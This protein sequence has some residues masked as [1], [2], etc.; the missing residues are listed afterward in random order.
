M[1]TPS[2]GDY[3][4]EGNP[5]ATLQNAD[6]LATWSDEKKKQ[7][8]DV[9]EDR[10]LAARYILKKTAE[11]IQR[12]AVDRKFISYKHTRD[13]DRLHGSVDISKCSRSKEDLR[14]IADE[15]ASLILK[16]LPTLKKA[17]QWIDPETS[18][19][20]ERKDK[21][22]VKANEL[23]EKLDEVCQTI[24]MADLDQKM[25]IGAFR[26]LV[27][28]REKERKAL[29]RKLE[30]VGEE[31]TKLEDTIAKKLYAGLPGLSDAVVQTI[32]DHWERFTALDQMGRRVGEQVM[33]GDSE[34]AMEILRK[35]EADEV[36]ISDDL[37]SRIK[38]A[39]ATLKA[40]AKGGGKKAIAGKKASKK[41]ASKK[42]SRK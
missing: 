8:L 30:D 10:L 25:S 40:S 2:T 15:R 16:E 5:L 29:L 19:M 14:A 12:K 34:S 31:G 3:M 6:T 35:F 37:K 33:F 13:L 41:K 42:V 11:Y 27:A 26:K 1:T 21:L 17:V 20:I 23:R 38:D 7:Y 18:K 32:K 4:L 9:F 22:L 39:V 36:T 24:D 28:D